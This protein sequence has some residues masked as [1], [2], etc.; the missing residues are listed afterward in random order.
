MI[1]ICF[2]FR[3]VDPGMPLETYEKITYPVPANDSVQF[4]YLFCNLITKTIQYEK[5]KLAAAKG[6][7]VVKE[8]ELKIG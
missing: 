5:K 2:D 4:V 3:L 1:V 7:V 8:E 6:K